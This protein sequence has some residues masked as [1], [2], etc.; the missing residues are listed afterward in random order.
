MARTRYEQR[1]ALLAL[2]AYLTTAGWSGITYRDGYQPDNTITNPQVVVTIPPK[3]IKEL[4][5]GRG[6]DK[7]FAVRILVNAYME[8]EPRAQA[9]I[10]DIMD[11]MDTECIDIIDPDNDTLGY[12]QVP[13]SENI[14][15]E[16]LP[17]IM[18]VPKLLRWRA[19]VRGDYEAFYPAAP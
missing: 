18:N 10:D 19:T 13:N 8:N 14:L 15:G 11:F 16:V 6:G 9:I 17:P 7:L 5:L 12:L 3:T 4:Q 2:E 1:S